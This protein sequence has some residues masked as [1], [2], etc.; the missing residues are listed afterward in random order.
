MLHALGPR[1][2]AWH[3]SAR[4]GSAQN[5]RPKVSGSARAIRRGQV[6]L[7][8]GVGHWRDLVAARRVVRSRRGALCHP[9]RCGFDGSLDEAGQRAR[10]NLTALFEADDYPVEAMRREE[11]GTV[12]VDLQIDRH[13]RVS[14]C[15][16]STSSGSDALDRKTC[17]ILQTRARFTPATDLD[18]RPVPD[19]YS[20]RI[21]WRLE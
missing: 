5:A 17:E 13:G 3:G 9:S 20:Q 2:K 15:T 16:V 18:G 12:G 4:E 19:V 7:P 10:G 21:T 14:R 11:Q 1:W 8:G 6:H